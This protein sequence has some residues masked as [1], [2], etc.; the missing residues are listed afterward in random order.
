VVVPMS[1]LVIMVRS[2]G[3]LIEHIRIAARGSESAA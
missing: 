1:A 2:V 3:V